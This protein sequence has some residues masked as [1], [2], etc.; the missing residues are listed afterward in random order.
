MGI[1]QDTIIYPFF[2]SLR[3]Q[4]NLSSRTIRIKDTIEKTSLLR[5]S[6]AVQMVPCQYIFTSERGKPLYY[7]K[8]DPKMAGPKM[9]IIKRFHCTT[10]HEA[11]E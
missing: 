1:T 6:F 5:T 2:H 9:S 10:V 8:N 3:I 7:S 4:W 11:D